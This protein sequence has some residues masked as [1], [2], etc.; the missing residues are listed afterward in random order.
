VDSKGLVVG[1]MTVWFEPRMQGDLFLEAGG[2]DTASLL[3]HLA[4]KP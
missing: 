4:K 2:E 1:V 3:D